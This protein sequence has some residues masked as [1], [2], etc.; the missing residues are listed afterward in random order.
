MAGKTDEAQKIL[1]EWKGY[2][3]LDSWSL[4]LLAETCSVMG[5][6]TDAFEFLEVAY[7][8]RS[9]VLILLNVA[10]SLRN[11]RT[12]PRYADLLRRMR[13]PQAPLPH[14]EAC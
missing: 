13:L 8:Q 5:E 2:R 6:K 11:I 4:M 14:P 1:V 12:D 10:P 3:N 7:Q 9:S